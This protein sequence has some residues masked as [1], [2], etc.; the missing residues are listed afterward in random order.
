MAAS[1][2]A[3]CSLLTNSMASLDL[4]LDL[5]APP[6]SLMDLPPDILAC[7]A[8]WPRSPR[9]AFRLVCRS[10]NLAV[11]TSTTQ[12]T[13][14]GSPKEAEAAPCLP[15][16][17]IAKCPMLAKLD[18]K[19]L[20]KPPAS[21]EGLPTAL[22]VF[23]CWGAASSKAAR[24]ASRTFLSPLV[25]C[26]GSLRELDVGYFLKVSDLAPLSGCSMLEVLCIRNT[27][28]K[29]LMPLSACRKLLNLDCSGTKILDL[30][31][32]ATCMDLRELN[33]S[34]TKT[35]SVAP[36][37]SCQSLEAVFCER[38]PVKDLS[39]LSACQKLLNLDCSGTKIL[40]LAALAACTDLRELNFSKTKAYS[41]APLASCK[42]LKEVVCN[43]TLLR[44]LWPLAACNNLSYLHCNR[45]I[46]GLVKRVRICYPQG[47]D[48]YDITEY[49]H[50]ALSAD[51][52]IVVEGSEL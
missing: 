19:G 23:R 8:M 22:E 52:E 15:V 29:D 31:P 32:L 28:V 12:I 30:A 9:G 17:L 13:W 6:K 42:S 50:P 45:D 37:A 49:S 18:V 51:V 35:F 27:Q 33:F 20:R 39:P 25:A 46:E 10:C 44:D 38:A 11:L 4:D 48:A 7:V 21:L 3:E 24:V 2:A 26:S 43:S 14:N 40:D 36:L 5:T 1:S 16:R 34:R 41:V 47:Y